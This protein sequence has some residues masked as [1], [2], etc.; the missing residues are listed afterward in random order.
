MCEVI[1]S[2]LVRCIITKYGNTLCIG[3]GEVFQHYGHKFKKSDLNFHFQ[4]EF[5]SD[6]AEW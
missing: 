3:M 6:T 2:I 1:R 5:S 4:Y